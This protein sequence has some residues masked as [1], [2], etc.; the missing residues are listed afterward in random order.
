[1]LILLHNL[2]FANSDIDKL[3]QKLSMIF[4]QEL[5]RQHISLCQ[6]TKSLCLEFTVWQEYSKEEGR[7]LIEIQSPDKWKG[8]QLLHIDHPEKEDPF[9][10][11]LPALQK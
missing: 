4:P 3:E 2:V 11:Y 1:M 6:V 5:S 10:I 9:W 7:Q 8:V